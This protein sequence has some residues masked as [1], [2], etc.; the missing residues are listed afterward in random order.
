M[1]VSPQDLAG[2][3]AGRASS[4][5]DHSAVH[6]HVVSAFPQIAAGCS[7]TGIRAETHS[8]PGRV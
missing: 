5:D 4:I 6:E 8:W 1:S 7:W 3:T 2:E